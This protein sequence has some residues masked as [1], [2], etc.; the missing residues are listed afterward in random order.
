MTTLAQPL[1]ET[2]ALPFKVTLKSIGKRRV[3]AGSLRPGTFLSFIGD[4]EVFVVI[5]NSA[6]LRKVEIRYHGG[7]QRV[8][9]WDSFLGNCVVVAKGRKRKYWDALPAWGKVLV[10]PYSRPTK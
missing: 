4:E 5:Q 9:S 8:H 10:C 1:A 6:K 2:S 3:D 7:A